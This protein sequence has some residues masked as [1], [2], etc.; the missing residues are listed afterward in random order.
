METAPP[1]TD[2]ELRDPDNPEVDETALQFLQ[3]IE[4]K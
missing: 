3:S 1:N 2:N 4:N